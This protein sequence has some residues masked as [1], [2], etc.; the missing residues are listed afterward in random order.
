[1]ISS[2]KGKRRFPFRLLD[3]S[4]GYLSVLGTIDLL[5]PAR[6]GLIDL[7]DQTS[8]CCLGKIPLQK[9]ECG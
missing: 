5:Q 4:S 2:V 7:S 3:I 9:I 6:I 1:M 8:I